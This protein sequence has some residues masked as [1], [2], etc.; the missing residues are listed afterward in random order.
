M[1][2]Q[3]IVKSSYITGIVMFI[4]QNIIN[5]HTVINFFDEMCRINQINVDIYSYKCQDGCLRSTINALAIVQINDLCY[6]LLDY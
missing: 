3:V 6:S 5:K 1:A 4:T 2:F